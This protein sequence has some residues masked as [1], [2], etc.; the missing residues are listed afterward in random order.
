MKKSL[1]AIVALVFFFGSH[2]LFAQMKVQTGVFNADKNISNFMLAAG[3]D[4][5]RTQQI[6]VTFPKPFTK[7]PDIQIS[8]TRIDQDRGNNT[9]YDVK[10]TNAHKAG[11][12]VEVK[13]WGG[14]KIYLIGGTYMAIGE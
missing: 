7:T 2:T 11:F 13:T 6:S 1:V 9:R 8:V 5:E 14:S 4:M 3:G 10:V 12:M